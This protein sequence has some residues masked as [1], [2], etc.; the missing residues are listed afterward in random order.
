MRLDA[1]VEVTTREGDGQR[2]ELLALDP[3]RTETLPSRIPVPLDRPA[4]K[5]LP[6]QSFQGGVESPLWDVVVYTD[7]MTYS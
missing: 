6:L 4:P 1:D 7:T 5:T 2:A 3:N